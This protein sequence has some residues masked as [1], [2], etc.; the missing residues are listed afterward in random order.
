ML[1]LKMQYLLLVYQLGLFQWKMTENI[2]H[3][4]LYNNGKLL[5]H[6]TWQAWIPEIY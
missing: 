4:S 3:S 6:I 1:S 5:T 2:M